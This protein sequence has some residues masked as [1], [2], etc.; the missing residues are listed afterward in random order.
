VVSI[1]IDPITL[2][3]ARRN[4]ARVGYG[5]LILILGDGGLGCPEQSPYDCVAVTA[6]CS[7][8]PPPLVDQLD[9]GGRLAAPYHQDQGAAQDL[10]LLEKRTPGIIR[11]RV[12]CQVLYVPLQGA[13]QP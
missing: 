9:T 2:A 6:A 13:Y 12:L 11:T 5:D 1:E 3:F 4:L 8:V 10:I 7:E